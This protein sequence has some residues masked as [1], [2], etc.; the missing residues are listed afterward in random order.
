MTLSPSWK[1]PVARMNVG[2]LYAHYESIVEWTTKCLR[3]KITMQMIATLISGVSLL[4][5]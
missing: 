4:F 3:Q 5:F 1:D 2:E